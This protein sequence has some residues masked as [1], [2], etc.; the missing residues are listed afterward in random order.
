MEPETPGT[1]V[2][3]FV[4]FWRG[5]DG[6]NSLTNAYCWEPSIDRIFLALSEIGCLSAL[7]NENI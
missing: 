3:F 1:T 7:R 2:S 4:I 6:I 5:A